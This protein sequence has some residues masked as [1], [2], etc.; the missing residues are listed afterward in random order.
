[1]LANFVEPNEIKIQEIIDD[2]DFEGTRIKALLEMPNRSE[3]FQKVTDD[4]IDILFGTND[5][6]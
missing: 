4:N 3:A 1:M 2:P 6:T 5:D